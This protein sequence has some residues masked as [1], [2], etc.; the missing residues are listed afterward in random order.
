MQERSLIPLARLTKD[1]AQATK[2]LSHQEI[3]FLVDLYYDL[4]DQRIG[5]GGQV[6]AAEGAESP[7][8]TLK[9]FYKQM[10]SL[11][12]QVKKTLD[13]WTNEDELAGWAKSLIG[14]GPVISAG[15]RAHI[16]ISKVQT[17]GAIWRYAGLDPTLK[18][19][20]GQI[21]P[22]NSTLK[23]LCWK[24]GESFI[25]SQNHKDSVY[26]PIYAE[27]KQAELEKNEAGEF[28]EQAQKKLENFKIG[29][30]TDAYKWYSQGKLPPAHIHARARRYA[31]K[32]FLA[33][34]FEVGYMMTHNESPPMPYA[35]AH[36]PGHVHLK[37][38]PNL[39]STYRE[40][41][42]A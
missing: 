8:E 9:W 2:E 13:W 21:R 18:W 17:A 4:Q 10:E 42:N 30:D 32:L 22:W 20:K 15:L 29:K 16:D 37:P 34:Y 36:I 26:G 14:I 7:H 3:R 11:E 39:P 41:A 38:I 27:R 6:R 35:I 40:L 23:T 24:I 12:N 1:L 19:E 25:K 31:V 28:E 33:H 5:L